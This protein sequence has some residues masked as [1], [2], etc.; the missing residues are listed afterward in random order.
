M[1]EA[2]WWWWWWVIGYL[3][4]G[5]MLP[6]LT[7][8]SLRKL[9]TGHW[10]TAPPPTSS[11]VTEHLSNVDSTISTGTETQLCCCCCCCSS[12]QLFTTAVQSHSFRSHGGGV[13]RCGGGAGSRC[14]NTVQILA[15][16]TVCIWCCCSCV[17]CHCSLSS[18]VVVVCRGQLRPRA[19]T[20]TFSRLQTVLYPL[21]SHTSLSRDHGAT[22]TTTTTQ[23]QIYCSAQ[24]RCSAG[25]TADTVQFRIYCRRQKPRGLLI[26]TAAPNC[27]HSLDI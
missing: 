18:A 5:Q 17:L 13:V 11:H 27:I 24:V 21:S 19:G 16:I 14:A 12:V 26:V 15:K 4:S 20:L 8:Y 1:S 23:V 10:S 22:T 7:T 6:W 3:F 2:S 9:G 25:C